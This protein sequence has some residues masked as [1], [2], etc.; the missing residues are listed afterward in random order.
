MKSLETSPE[1]MAALNKFLMVIGA[2]MNAHFN[3][4]NEYNSI[5]MRP[6]AGP[7]YVKIEKTGGR[8][9]ARDGVYCFID[10]TNGDVLK[11]ASWRGP[12]KHARGNIFLC[13]YLT[14][15]GA[16]GLRYLNDKKLTYTFTKPGTDLANLDV[17]KDMLLM[18]RTDEAISHLTDLIRNGQ[19]TD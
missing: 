4:D 13:D 5:I 1:F 3:P 9:G 15:C 18:D 6:S 10:K 14:T 2:Q 7:R 11:P 17:L 19:L 12:A 8:Y 16:Y